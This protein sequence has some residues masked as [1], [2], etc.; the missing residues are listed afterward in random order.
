MTTSSF[1]NDDIIMLSCAQSS[2]NST[3]KMHSFIYSNF[4]VLVPGS[5]G[6][7][8]PSGPASVG[9]WVDALNFAVITI[10]IILFDTQYSE[11]IRIEL[12]EKEE[13]AL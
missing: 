4:C 13:N 6:A 10:Q 2:N 7:D 3:A 9:L 5:Q 1:N 11:A 8:C 12:K